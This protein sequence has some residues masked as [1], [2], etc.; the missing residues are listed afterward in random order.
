MLQVTVNGEKKEFPAKLS[1]AQALPQ[2]GFEGS[3]FAVAL[4]GAFIPRGQYSEKELVGGETLEILAP[5]Q[6]G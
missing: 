4:D 5:R 6:G 1:L 3:Y 2:L